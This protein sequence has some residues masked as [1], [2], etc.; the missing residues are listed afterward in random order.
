MKELIVFDLDNTLARSKT[1][2]DEEMSDLL[3]KLLKVKKVAVISG[4]SFKQFEKELLF[5]LK[6]TSNLSNLHIFPTDGAAYYIWIADSGKW[7][8][9]YQEVLTEKE[10]VQINDAFSQVLTEI[11]FDTKGIIG[12]LIEDRQSSITF[13]GLGQNADLAEKEVWDPDGKKRLYIKKLLEKRLGNFEIHIAGTTSIDI[14]AKG[15]DKAYGIRKMIEY[16]QVPLEKM[17]YV[18]DSLFKGGNDNPVIATGVET[19][20]VKSP[21][22]TKVIIKD[23]LKQKNK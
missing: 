7:Q 3:E 5:N 4:G 20:A 8:M 13:S 15:L 21:E 1:T 11:N 12:E 14:T 23:L 6:M 17:L 22:E 18:G 10:K 2:I 19:I 9:I 16:I